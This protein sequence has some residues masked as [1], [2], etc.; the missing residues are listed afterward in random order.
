MESNTTRRCGYPKD[1]ERRRLVKIELAKRD[2]T[3]TDLAVSL[4]MNRGYVSDV[5][6][7]VRR[8]RVNETKIAAFFGLTREELFPVRTRGDLEAMRE[9]EKAA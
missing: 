1:W 3:I 7:G 9:R 5:I 6:C 8:S 2:M 4:G